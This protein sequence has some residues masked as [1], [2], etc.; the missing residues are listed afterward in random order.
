TEDQVVSNDFLGDTRTSIF[1]AGAGIQLSDKFV[2]VVS[3]YDNEMGYS[4]KVVDLIMYMD[5]VK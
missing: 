2:K 4:A 5:S 1:D 3:W